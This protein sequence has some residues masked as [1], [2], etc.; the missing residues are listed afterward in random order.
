M[1]MLVVTA[2][3]NFFYF[4]HIPIVQVLATQLDATPS[5]AGIIKQ[6]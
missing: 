2:F 5:Q 1:S 4:S 6:N 3:G